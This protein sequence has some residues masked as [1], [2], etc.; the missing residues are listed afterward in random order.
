MGGGSTGD[1]DAGNIEQSS[2]ISQFTRDSI[3]SSQTLEQIIF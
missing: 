1:S 3:Q 2:Q